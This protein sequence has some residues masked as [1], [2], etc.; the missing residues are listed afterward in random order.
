MKDLV[1]HM[2]RAHGGT[3]LCDLCEAG[4]NLF[5]GELEI[6]PSGA[7]LERHCVDGDTT[8]ATPFKGHPL[9]EFCETRHY[10]NDAL[11]RH[12]KAEHHHC[13]CCGA[14][15]VFA[16]LATVCLL[17]PVCLFVPVLF[18]LGVLLLCVVFFFFFR[19]LT[20]EPP[21]PNPITT[22]CIQPNPRAQRWPPGLFPGPRLARCALQ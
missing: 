10:D 21:Y 6:F 22:N 15:C 16:L 11:W 20:Q 4:G 2:T 19:W 1:R 13:H 12:L 9:C 8:G 7:A 17:V 5:V 18:V 14:R 3:A